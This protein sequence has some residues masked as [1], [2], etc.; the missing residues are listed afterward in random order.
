MR[1]KQLCVLLAVVSV[2]V[3]FVGPAVCGAAEEE[4]QEEEITLAKAPASVRATLERESRKG[5]IEEITRKSQAGRTWYEAD[6]RIAGEKHELVLAPDGKITKRGIEEEEKTETAPAPKTE[7]KAK[8]AVEKKSAEK[9]EKKAADKKAPAKKAAKSEG[10]KEAKGQQEILELAQ[11]PSAVRATLLRASRG[12]SILEIVEAVEGKQVVYKAGLESNGKKREIQIAPD[13]KLIKTTEKKDDGKKAVE[14][15]KADRSG[16]TAKKGQ[17]AAESTGW[18]DTFDVDKADLVSTG[19]N[20]YFSLEPGYVLRFKNE[21]G[22]ELKITVL[23]ETRT[24]D[25]VETRVV[26]ERETKKGQL[27][28]VSLNWFAIN[29]K[30][31][32]VYYFGEDSMDYKNGKIVGHSGSWEA[33]KNGARFGMIMPGKPQVGQKHYQEVAPK[34]AMDRAENVS[35]AE[36]VK[37][38]AGEF[39]NCLKTKESSGIEKGTEYKLYAPGVGLLKDGDFE[40]VS[41]GVEKPQAK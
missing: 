27:A 24:I 19:R 6:V 21:D 40:L 9:V 7:A 39:K 2:A 29:R 34:V 10:K 38:P 31:G 32:D 4:V 13:G 8:A 14:G 26:E 28:E 18:M 20:P 25:G 33:G 11:L 36:T 12:A 3:G 23:N 1:T 35:L 5:E 41:Y 30:T 37:V 22:D 16:P 15:K 17:P